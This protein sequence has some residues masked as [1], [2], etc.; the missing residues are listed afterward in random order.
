MRSFEKRRL[1]LDEK[2]F[3]LSE[4]M[5]TML[6]MI[7]VLF[8]LYS[9]FDMS[10]RI[11]SFGNDKVEAVENARLG[12]EKMKR[13]I[14]AAYPYDRTNVSTADDYLFASG[15]FTANSITFANDSNGN[16]KVD[17]TPNEQ[18]TYD[19]SG[20]TLRRTVG[21]GA[22]QPVVEFVQDVDGDSSSLTFTYLESDGV[23]EVAPGCNPDD[24]AEVESCIAMVRIK[25]EVAVDRG[26]HQDPVTQILTTDVSLRNRGDQQ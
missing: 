3:T 13:E 19:L 15:G 1:L 16:Y 25:L 18:I 11:F 22:A 26:I 4:V 7:M 6:I 5:V 17:T 10:L 2:G 12:L 20:T 23:T 14:R 8:A 9:I 24:L 21:A